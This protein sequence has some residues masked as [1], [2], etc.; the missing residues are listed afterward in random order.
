[1]ARFVIEMR[2]AVVLL[3]QADGAD[4]AVTALFK[5]YLYPQVEPGF[6]LVGRLV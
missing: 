1:M 5:V 6:R 3:W 2:G 4:S